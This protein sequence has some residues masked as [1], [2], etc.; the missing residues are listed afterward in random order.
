MLS[1]EAGTCCCKL[2]YYIKEVIGSSRIGG[3]CSAQGAGDQG[4]VTFA[5]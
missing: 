1:A 5:E 2:G 4:P 3:W